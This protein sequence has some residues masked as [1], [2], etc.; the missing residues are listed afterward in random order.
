MTLEAATG[1]LCCELGSPPAARS[2]QEGRWILLS[3][4]QRELSPALSLFWTGSLLNCGRVHFLFFRKTCTIVLLNEVCLPNM[5]AKLLQ[6]RPILC[7]PMHCSPARLLCPW[8][9]SRPEYWS[10]LPC[11]PPGDFPNPGIEPSSL[12][13]PA[14]V[15]RFSTTS[16]ASEAQRKCWDEKMLRFAAKRFVY[17]AAK[18]AEQVSGVLAQGQ[19]FRIIM[20]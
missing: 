15:G 20:G 10:G 9:F 3:R 2:C 7:G 12:K 13:S 1:G 5:Q 18:H 16:A 6:S 14:M 8:G 4:F 19:G 17:K 11:P